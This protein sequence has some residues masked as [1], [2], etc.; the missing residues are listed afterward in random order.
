MSCE[1]CILYVYRCHRS[2]SF[3]M[4]ERVVFL[5]SASSSAAGGGEFQCLFF[6]FIFSPACVCVCI[7]NPGI[8]L[9][10]LTHSSISIP[11]QSAMRNPS[12][13][14][15]QNLLSLCPSSR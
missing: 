7:Q 8:C 14:A 2:H 4:S 5:L 9:T 12:S 1:W 10:G 13:G 6:L 11:G 3:E 15:C